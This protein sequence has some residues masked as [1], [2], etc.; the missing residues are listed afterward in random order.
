MNR[1][2]VVGTPS[3]TSQS[4]VHPLTLDGPPGGLP[5]LRAQMIKQF[6]SEEV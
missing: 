5:M 2:F 6:E 1:T 4:R 3:E